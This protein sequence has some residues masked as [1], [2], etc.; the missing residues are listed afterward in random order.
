MENSHEKTSFREHFIYSLIT[1]K[2]LAIFGANNNF[3]TTMGSM[4]LRSIVTGGFPGRI[5]PIHPKLDVVQGLK[6]YKSV[7]DLPETPDLAF[8]ILPTQVVPKVLEE[9]GQKGINKLII[10][11]GGFREV[12]AEGKKLSQQIREIANKYNM[13]FIGPNC[14]GVY[15]GWYNPDSDN[16]KLNTTWVYLLPDR[17]KISIASQSGTVATHVFWHSKNR[18]IKI[19]RSIS[20]GNENNI[21]LVDF[22]S[23]FKEDPY[24]NTIGL[25]IEEIRRGPEFIKLAKEITPK[26]PIVAIYV[27]GSKAGARTVLSHTGA[28]GGNE[29]IHNA[30]FK[31]TGIIS[32]HSITEFLSYLRVLSTE[33]FPKGNRVG[34]LTNSGGPGAMIANAL[35]TNGL[36]IPEFSEELQSQLSGLL[37]HTASYKNPIDLTFDVNPYKFYVTFPKMLIQSGEVD[38]IIVHGVFGF[39][40]FLEEISKSGQPIDDIKSQVS[41]MDQVFLK[42]IKKLSRK[43]SIPIMYIAPQGYTNSWFKKISS[44][45]LPIFE[46]WDLPTKC[47]KILWEYSKYRMRNS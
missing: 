44:M 9:C 38:S 43:Y 10:T 19:G 16:E 7:L 13:R 30:V 17:G 33:I 28:I 40:E 24:T 11:S 27:G 6:S 2:S 31:E 26:K 23:F 20:V 4:Q 22:L 34:I 42:P 47:V 8:I 14:L 36:E 25:Y 41:N 32:T 39:Q 5:Y 3:L 45:D 1:P 35:E 18:G 29:K 37:P 21:D 46:L 15:N 12:G